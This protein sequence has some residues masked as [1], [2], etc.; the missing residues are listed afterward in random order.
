MRC[1]NIFNHSNLIEA[2][3]KY[4]KLESR[5]KMIYKRQQGNILEGLRTI[6]PKLFY[7]KFAKKRRIIPKVS[8]NEFLEHFKKIATELRTE[9]GSL[10]N[11]NVNDDEPVYE[12]LDRIITDDEI[13]VAISNLK[14]SK[15]HGIDG[16]LNEYFIEYKDLLLPFSGILISGLFPEAWSIAVMVPVFKRG[17]PSCLAK[18]FTNIISNRLIEWSKTYHTITNAQFGFRQGLSTVDALFA[19]KV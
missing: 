14:R 17:D 4:K 13:L 1:L 19:Q 10:N 3:K 15:S 9:N 6:N 11:D 8:G 16:L 5:L 7:G 2:K 18:L 12:E